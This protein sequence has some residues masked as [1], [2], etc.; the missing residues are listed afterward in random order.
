VHEHGIKIA[1][2][3]SEPGGVPD[4]SMHE[5]QLADRNRP[6]DDEGLERGHAD[7]FAAFDF[8][9]PLG[10]VGRSGFECGL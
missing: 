4:G 1:V 8:Q 2:R 9:L 6:R 3:D 7:Q 10:A 5:E